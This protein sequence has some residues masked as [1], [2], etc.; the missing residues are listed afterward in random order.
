MSILPCIFVLV[1]LFDKSII[2][3]NIGGYD[4]KVINIF[5]QS[6]RALSQHRF[7]NSFVF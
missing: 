5:D 3:I 1:F 6:R 4:I 2:F 7:G